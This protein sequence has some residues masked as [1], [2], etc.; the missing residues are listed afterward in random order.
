MPFKKVSYEQWTKDY[1]KYVH[2]DA[3]E[4]E[5]KESYDRIQIPTRSTVESAGYDFTIP[6]KFTAPASPYNTANGSDANN[7]MLITGIRWK[8]PSMVMKN[9]ALF[10]FARSGMAHKFG[11]APSNCVGVVD[12]DYYNSDNE[13]HIMVSINNIGIRRLRQVSTFAPG[14]KVVQGVIMEFY[15]DEDAELAPKTERNGGH[16][17]TGI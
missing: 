8:K 11:V 1:L 2:P 16:G 10:L 13:G 3:T 5:I 17:S 6:Y 12:S 9:L 4:D 15:T 7:F 14:T